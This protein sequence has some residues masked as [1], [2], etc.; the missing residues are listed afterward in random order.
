MSNEEWKSMMAVKYGHRSWE[1]NDP[2]P[3]HLDKRTL[4]V[5]LD[6]G[7]SALRG[8]IAFEV[9]HTSDF[10]DERR[11]WTSLSLGQVRELIAHLD[12]LVGRV[13]RDAL[14]DQT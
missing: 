14:G 8:D 10:G 12:A 13:E 4:N 2:R 7:R 6:A 5:E 11:L 3:L 1:V 9:I